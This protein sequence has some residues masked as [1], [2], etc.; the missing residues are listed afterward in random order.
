MGRLRSLNDFDKTVGTI[1]SIFSIFPIV[2]QKRKKT[3]KTIYNHFFRKFS[4]VSKDMNNNKET[5][6]FRRWGFI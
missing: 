1:V 6:A 4:S 3:Q 2:C 5:V